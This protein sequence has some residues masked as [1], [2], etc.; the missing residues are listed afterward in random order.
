MQR[1]LKIFTGTKIVRWQPHDGGMTLLSADGP[2]VEAKKVVFATG[3]ETMEF[4]PRNLCQLASTYAF[5][6]QPFDSPAWPRNCLIW[7]SARPYLY[8]R[9]TQDNR[10][11]VGGE[12]IEIVDPRLRDQLLPEK[13]RTLQNRIGRLMPQLNIETDC[14][15]AGTFAQTKDGLP[16]IGPHPG[17]PHA[18]FALG[19]GG[20]GIT[21]KHPCGANHFVF[22]YGSEESYCGAVWIWEVRKV[23]R[24]QQV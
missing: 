12:D 23:Y 5:V 2:R 17:F 10:A 4:L 16:Y 19:Y 21:F 7:E 6:S 24:V 1:G 22:I 13:T 3:Y 14:A 9:T 15:W 20:N 11:I 8:F 18:Y